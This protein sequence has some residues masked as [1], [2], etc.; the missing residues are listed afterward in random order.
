MPHFFGYQE[1][2]ATEKTARVR[3][4]FSKVAGKYDVMNDFMSVGVH[5]LWKRQFV[6]RINPR[7]AHK[8]LDVAGGTGD[9]SF[10]V[11]DTSGG[12]DI[13]VSDINPEMLQVGQARAAD[14]GLVG[15]LR[16]AEANAETLPFEDNSFDIYTIAFGLRNVTHID[17]ALREAFRVLKPGGKFYCLEFSK[18]VIAPLRKFYDAYS[19]NVIPKLGEIVAKDRDS[20]QYLV[21][22]IRQFPHQQGLKIRLEDAG[23]KNVTFENLSAGIAAIH[24][25]VKI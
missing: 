9:I 25:G 6:R 15:K 5:R 16:W 24:C 7:A 22:S 23:F 4:V 10:L 20:Y 17:Q 3:D 21:E 14:H 12:A 19:F 18:P 2:D 1:V 8:I 13:T 11:Y